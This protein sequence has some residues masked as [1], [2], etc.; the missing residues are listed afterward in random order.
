MARYRYATCLS[1]GGDEPTAELEVEVSYTVAWGRP[2]TPPAYDHGGLPAD[3]D[4]I[5]NLATQ[6]DQRAN[7]MRLNSMVN[8][9]VAREVGVDDGRE[10]PGPADLYNQPLAAGQTHGDENA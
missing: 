8:A 4:E 2:E 6:G 7:I 1:W 5:T 10:Y 9:L 3:P